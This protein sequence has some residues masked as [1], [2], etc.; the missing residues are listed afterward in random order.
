[1]STQQSLRGGRQDLA[2]LLT[3]INATAQAADT[4]APGRP[5]IRATQANQR[6]DDPTNGLVAYAWAHHMIERSVAF[7]ATDAGPVAE[8]VIRL[9]AHG[10]DYLEL[11]AIASASTIRR[12]A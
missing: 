6:L 8:D 7:G 9:T 1:M 3:R 5:Y 12:A 11:L 10:R 4:A 2:H